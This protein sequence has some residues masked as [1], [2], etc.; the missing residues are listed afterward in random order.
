[1][2]SD[3]KLTR[4]L[5]ITLNHY[6]KVFWQFRAS[7]AH[8]RHRARNLSSPATFGLPIQ[9]KN[10]ARNVSLT[11]LF[12][13]FELK[14]KDYIKRKIN[15]KKMLSWEINIIIDLIC[16]KSGLVGQ[17]KKVDLALIWFDREVCFIRR[18]ISQRGWWQE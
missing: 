7:C 2:L 4:G 12:D 9:T 6:L 13:F 17:K 5:K 11:F 16:G 3:T 15:S 14:E 8:A 10:S 1:M 18:L